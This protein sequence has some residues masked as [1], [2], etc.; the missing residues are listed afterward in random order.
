MAN[1]RPWRCQYYSEI[2]DYDVINGIGIESSPYPYVD[3]YHL[4]DNR[5]RRCINVH[6]TLAE[7]N[8]R[9]CYLTSIAIMLHETPPMEAYVDYTSR[10]NGSHTHDAYVP[11]D[12]E[13][14]MTVPPHL[15][16][17]PRAHPH[18]HVSH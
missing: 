11:T 2:D 9:W 6:S 13:R 18:A 16:L 12:N 8:C 3:D 5:C 15:Q 4:A 10:A 7:P 1:T 14:P 17:A